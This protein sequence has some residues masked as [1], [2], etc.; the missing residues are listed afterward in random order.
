V[1]SAEPVRYREAGR[2]YLTT[3]ILTSVIV[4]GFVLD[5]VIGAG[6]HHIVGWAIAL[7]IVVG[8][9]ALTVYAARVM[10]TVTITDDEISVGEETLSRSTVTGVKP[11]GDVDDRVLGRKYATGLPRGTQGVC[12][13]LTDGSRAVI[14]TRHL[15]RVLSVLGAEPAVELAE[16]RIAEP[17]ELARVREIDERAE[18]LFRVAG[19]DLPV[20][21]P[22]PDHP[23]V[24]RTL[25]IGRPAVGFVELAEVDGEGYVAELAVLPS[26]MRRGHGTTLMQ[27]ATDWAREQGYRVI[28]LTTFAEIDWNAPFYRRLGFEDVG[29][30]SGQLA[31]IRAYE[32]QVGLDA[33]SPRIV[34]RREL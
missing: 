7:V 13:E 15:D 17:D 1:T 31:R 3:A 23:E 11:G 26:H 8:S 33:V 19:Y 29:T 14:A 20:F 32:Q 21:E 22:S 27:G 28:A 34:M 9:E 10:R 12:L 5:L 4:L 18:S 24:K 2:T 6:V 25:V 30:P 16:L